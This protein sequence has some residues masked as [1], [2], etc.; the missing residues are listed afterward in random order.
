MKP[1]KAYIALSLTSGLRAELSA[2]TEDGMLKFI[3]LFF[4][5]AIFS[6]SFCF[7]DLHFSIAG[8]RQFLVDEYISF[9]RQE[10]RDQIRDFRVLSST[11]NLRLPHLWYVSFRCILF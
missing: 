5:D 7:T 3:E 1:F 10:F 2:K 6:P 4:D 11:T 8:L 9:V